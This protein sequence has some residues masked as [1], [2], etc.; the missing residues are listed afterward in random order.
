M[1]SDMQVASGYPAK[2]QFLQDR[3]S[4]DPPI[5]LSGGAM[6]YNWYRLLD[7]YLAIVI[8]KL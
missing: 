5:P 8:Y 2:R 6:E 1:A 3:R 7:L 4:H